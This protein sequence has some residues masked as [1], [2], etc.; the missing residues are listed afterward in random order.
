MIGG[1][2]SVAVSGLGDGEPSILWVQ[3]GE[4]YGLPQGAAQWGDETWRPYTRRLPVGPARGQEWR[5]GEGR[6]VEL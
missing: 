5:P 2:V 6:R 3:F 4:L 1:V